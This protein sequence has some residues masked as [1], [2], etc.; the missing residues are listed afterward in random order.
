MRVLVGPAILVLII[1]S[2][3]PAFA[4][5]KARG[6]YDRVATG[7][8][9]VKDSKVYTNADL[10]KLVGITEE[11]EREPVPADTGGAGAEKPEPEVPDP[12]LWLQQSEAAKK[13]QRAAVAEAEAAVAAAHQRVTDLEKELLAVSN[14]FA[15]RPKL[16]DEEKAKRAESKET[17]QERHERMKNML[18]EARQAARAADAELARV[19]AGRP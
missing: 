7:K 17:A 16:S 18:D 19:R 11:A 8:P 6:P 15:A 5:E 13:E 12:L 14:P 2:L 4:D 1:V 3:V 9:P 10:A